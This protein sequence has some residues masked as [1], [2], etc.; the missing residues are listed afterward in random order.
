MTVESFEIDVKKG[1]QIWKEQQKKR[2]EKVNG[3]L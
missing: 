3:I 2:S 1:F